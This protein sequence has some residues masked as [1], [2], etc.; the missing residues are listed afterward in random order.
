MRTRLPSR[1]ARG[2]SWSSRLGTCRWPGFEFPFC[3]PSVTVDLDD[4]AID[5]GKLEVRIVGERVENPLERIGRTARGPAV[6]DM[7]PPPERMEGHG[8]LPLPGPAGGGASDSERACDGREGRARPREAPAISQPPAGRLPSLAVIAA[9]DHW[10]C[11]GGDCGAGGL[12]SWGGSQANVIA[13]EALLASSSSM[14]SRTPA[15]DGRSGTSWPNQPRKPRN[16]QVKLPCD[17]DRRL[18]GS[19]AWSRSP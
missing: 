11:H 6:T 8:R 12:G 1:S 17:R 15:R 7:P 9:A 13:T 18:R 5:H 16:G 19:G 2:S 14:C 3:A 10:L 4:R